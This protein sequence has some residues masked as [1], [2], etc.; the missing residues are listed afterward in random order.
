[1]DVDVADES[2]GG[3]AGINAEIRRLI[4]QWHPNH[5]QANM[6]KVVAQNDVAQSGAEKVWKEFKDD[7]K[8]LQGT[9]NDLYPTYIFN[10]LFRRHFN[11]QKIF[12][13]ILFEI[14]RQYNV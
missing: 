13:H 11:N 12:N 3:I 14:R 2:F 8:K 4:M 10:F 1:M 7:L 9:S 5:I 6:I